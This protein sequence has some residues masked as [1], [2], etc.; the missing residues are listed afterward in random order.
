ML[1]DII[2]PLIIRQ[3]LQW[4]FICK[5]ENKIYINI[6]KLFVNYAIVFQLIC[7]K[8]EDSIYFAFSNTNRVWYISN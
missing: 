6:T 3:I 7:F 5:E 2:I 1:K 4:H 8:Y